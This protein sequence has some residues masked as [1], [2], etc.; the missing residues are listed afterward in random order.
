MWEN[1]FMKHSKR[2]DN[3]T[4]IVPSNYGPNRSKVQQRV[5]QL[6]GPRF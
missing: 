5:Q 4:E 1:G 6:T 3:G 2:I